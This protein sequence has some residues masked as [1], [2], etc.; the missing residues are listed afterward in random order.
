MTFVQA[1]HILVREVIGKKS[2][3][4]KY[5]KKM[6]SRPLYHANKYLIGRNKVVE[7]VED[8]DDL[9]YQHSFVGDGV[10]I[11]IFWSC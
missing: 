2:K 6:V 11:D 10:R 4:Y 7:D 8:T 1:K 3:D 5:P 9:I